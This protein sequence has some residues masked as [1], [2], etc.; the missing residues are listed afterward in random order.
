MRRHRLLSFLSLLLLLALG[1][2]MILASGHLQLIRSVI[3]GGGGTIQDGDTVI[4]GTIGQPIAGRIQNGNVE[5]CAGF[6]CQPE[7]TSTATPTATAAAATATATPTATATATATQVP[8]EY[9]AYLPLV[10]SD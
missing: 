8:T 1:A 2:S 5:L 10:Q 6:Q 7:A 3:S 4:H 9:F